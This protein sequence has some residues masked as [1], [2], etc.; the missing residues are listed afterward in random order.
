MPPELTLEALERAISNDELVLFYQP[1]VC[2]L[3]GT[4]VGAEALVRWSDETR[5]I[6]S[7]AE[8][9][10]LAESSGLLHDMTVKL[11][12]QVVDACVQI[13]EQN[14][15]L[16]IS[17]NVAPDDLASHTISDRIGALLSDEVITREELQIEITESAAMLNVE[18]VRDD[19]D[20]LNALGIK[21]LM[22]D[23]GTG[24]SSIDRL[25]QLP[26][27]ALKLDQ[28]VVKRMGT[29]VQNLDVVRAS[30]SMARELG[31]T[32]VA[33]GVESAA[34]YD[35]LT[36]NGCEEAQGYWIGRPMSLSDFQGFLDQPQSFNGSQIGRVHQTILNLLQF[37]KSLIDAA[38]CYRVSHDEALPSV[39][40]PE[41]STDIV[42]SR[43]GRWYFGMGSVL[44]A[45]DSYRVLNK[46]LVEIHDQ[47]LQFLEQLRGGLSEAEVDAF[48]LQ[49]D[50]RVDRLITLLHSLERD[51]L[52][53]GMR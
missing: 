4:V 15:G 52:R 3:T 25:S 51:L 47:G 35:F 46:P 44:E 12:D 2:L 30:I 38:F 33:E 13:R 16:A 18:R 24:Y 9:L 49:L 29:S 42:S 22:D 26:F 7:P 39:L 10:P 19:L 53:T 14:T 45:L 48:L 8:F 6:I 40:Y 31:M 32:S 37:R 1:K 28:G 5:D 20:T 11:L 43:V 50:S 36:A 23:F 41:H 27:S 21:V 17:M 34:A